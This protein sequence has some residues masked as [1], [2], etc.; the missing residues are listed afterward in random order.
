MESYRI[1]TIGQFTINFSPK[2]PRNKQYLLTIASGRWMNE[3]VH[4]CATFKAAERF[5]K[6]HKVNPIT[7]EVY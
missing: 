5:A 4:I 1:T 6:Q 2:S 7:A 3:V